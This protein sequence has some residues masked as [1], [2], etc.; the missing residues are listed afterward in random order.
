MSVVAE[1]CPNCRSKVII[2]RAVLEEVKQDLLNERRLSVK[3]HL[4]GI[5]SAIQRVEALFALAL[6][7]ERKA[8]E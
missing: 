8:G 4:A 3:E 6:P 2:R 1:M 5:D 7:T